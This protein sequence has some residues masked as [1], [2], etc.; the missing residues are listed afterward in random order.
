MKIEILRFLR[1]ASQKEKIGNMPKVTN[2]ID[3]EG[4]ENK[5][6]QKPSPS[7]S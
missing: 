2:K 4:K 7:K 1:F 5:K 6:I 3:K